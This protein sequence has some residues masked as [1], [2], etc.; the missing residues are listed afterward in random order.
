MT[1][2]AS[3][4]PERGFDAE[5]GLRR[6]RPRARTHFAI[7]LT[8]LIDVTFLLLMY[9]MLATDF[10]AEEEVYRLDLPDRQ[11]ERQQR[12]VFTLD[13][14]PLL[15]TVATDAGDERR[16]RVRVEGPYPQFESFDDLLA[17]LNS[18]RITAG[19]PGGLFEA[20]HPI[21]IRPTVGTRWEHAVEAFSAAARARFTNVIFAPPT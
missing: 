10:R 8:S 18:S 19:A 17:F 1:E 16:Y 4:I 6:R 5:L 12:H 13:D 21:V 15:I 2:A 20:D 14:D 7:N 11:A 3:T 9:F